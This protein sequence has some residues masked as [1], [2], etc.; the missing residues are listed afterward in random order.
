MAFL[1]VRNEDIALEIVQDTVL[2]GF[3]SIKAL[4]RPEAFKSWLTQILMH[5]ASDYYNQ[6]AKRKRTQIL[7]IAV[8]SSCCL[9]S[10]MIIVIH[11]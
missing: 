10:I 1:N 6:K 7:R 9:R 5:V 2:K 8:N 4:R 3:R 11:Q